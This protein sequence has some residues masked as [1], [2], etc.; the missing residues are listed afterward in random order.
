MNRQPEGTKFPLAF[1]EDI[2]FLHEV[3][4]AVLDDLKNAPVVN[5]PEVSY[6]HLPDCRPLR[7]MFPRGRGHVADLANKRDTLYFVGFI[8]YTREPSELDNGIKTQ[9]W[10]TDQQLIEQLQEHPLIAGYFSAER[11]D[12][13]NWGNLVVFDS[14]HAIQEWMTSK[15][16]ALAVTNLS[17]RY[18]RR[19][20]IHSGELRGGFYGEIQVRKTIFLD[21]E[22]PTQTARS[23]VHWET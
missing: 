19:V 18:Y 20:R 21:Y 16:H 11:A 10:D 12:S 22:S 15:T 2:N 17:P 9:I 7:R 5:T 6:G 3:K 23:V 8:G 4:T 1:L 13:Y 14:T